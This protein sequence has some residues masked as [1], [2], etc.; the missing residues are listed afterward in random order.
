LI[1]DQACQRAFSLQVKTNST[2][3]SFWLAGKHM[4]ISDTHIYVL[5]NLK[6]KDDA[7]LPEYF[8]VPSGIVKQRTVYSNPKSEFYSLYRKDI[9]DYRD[10]WEVLAILVPS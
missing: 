5:V 6:S 1:T 7:A 8:V 2:A 4:P 3:A 10:K 9:L